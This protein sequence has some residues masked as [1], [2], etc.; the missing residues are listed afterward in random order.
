MS[1]GW[2]HKW[3][4]VSGGLSE[5]WRRPAAALAV[6]GGG[7]GAAVW[8]AAVWERAMASGGLGA[9]GGLRRSIPGTRAVWLFSQRDRGWRGGKRDISGTGGFGGGARAHAW[10]PIPNNSVV[11]WPRGGQAIERASINSIARS[12]RSPPTTNA[13]V[14]LNND[15]NTACSSFG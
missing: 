5:L 13:E 2:R 12:H 14:D 9:G 4:R 1:G 15:L 8:A 3:G 10:S 11:V 6:F 7:A